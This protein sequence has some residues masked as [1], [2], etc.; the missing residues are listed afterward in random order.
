MERK[1]GPIPHR[2]GRR[3]APAGAPVR[4]RRVVV[5]LL[6]AGVAGREKLDGILGRVRGGARWRVSLYRSAAAF[7]AEAV[8]R[9]LALG[10]EGF[11]VG[12]PDAAG[13]MKA[14]A[15]TRVPVVAVDVASPALER[16]AEGVGFVRNDPVEI[17]RAAARELRAAGLRRSYGYAAWRE[18]EDWSRHRGRA[19]RE[20]LAGEDVRVFDP[21]RARGARG[22]GALE[23]WLRRLPKP[24]AVFACCDD[25]AWEVLDACRE[26]G[27]RVPED[28]AVL[29]VNDDPALCERSEPRLSSVRPDFAGEGRLAAA[30][31]D[32]M[33]DGSRPGPAWP[34]RRT[35]AVAGVT[36]RGSTR[37]ARGGAALV[38]RAADWLRAHAT[39]GVRVNDVA[40]AMHVSASLLERRFRETLGTPVYETALRIRLDEVRRRLGETGDSIETVTAA[41]GWPDPAPPKRLF[42]KRFGVS[43]REWRRGRRFA[44]AT[45]IR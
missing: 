13:A 45:A 26:L 31:L 23:R 25:T 3:G 9:E 20:A 14:L 19:F 8:R 17:G 4:L 28:V 21:A 43:M 44:S 37:A 7:T 2:T 32:G 42:K 18:P 30:L 6:T 36:R 38:A 1:P 24:C 40:R 35:V 16:R 33:M 41:C 10:A 27:L 39:E 22:C 11:L 34:V 15:G 5:A 12:L 29:G